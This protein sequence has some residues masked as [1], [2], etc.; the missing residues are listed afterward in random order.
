MNNLT[1]IEE[2]PKITLYNGIGECHVYIINGP[3]FRDTIV[4]KTCLLFKDIVKSIT[5]LDK[6]ETLKE[7]CDINKIQR[8]YIKPELHHSFCFTL[9]LENTKVGDY[10]VFLDSDEV[11]S[12][13]LLKFIKNN[14]YLKY[15]ADVFNV[16]MIPHFYN[17]YTNHLF[18]QKPEERPWCRPSLIRRNK[19]SCVQRLGR[20]S[21]IFTKDG[22]TLHIDPK[23]YT[24]HCKNHSMILFSTLAHGLMNPINHGTPESSPNFNIIHKFLYKNN[25]N[26]DDDK[27]LCYLLRQ[28]DFL[29]DLYDHLDKLDEPIVRDLNTFLNDFNGELKIYDFTKCDQK[30]CRHLRS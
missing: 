26:I 10:M 18:T 14:Q 8:I 7:Y 11:P 30:C 29:L 28:K 13:S 15:E 6:D 25:I 3:D 19:D 20:H 17:E 21:S 16:N 4:K 27:K 24:I 1:V 2:F 9:A 12:E 23:Y 22:V 5:I